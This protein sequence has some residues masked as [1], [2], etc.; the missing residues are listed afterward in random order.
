[1]Q[2]C[3]EAAQGG[4]LCAGE[5]AVGAKLNGLPRR[6]GGLGCRHSLGRRTGC[7]A[8]KGSLDALPPA[9][10]GAPCLG[11]QH[12]QWWPGG[13]SKGPVAAGGAERRLLAQV[14]PCLRAPA[15]L[16]W[17]PWARQGALGSGQ[18]FPRLEQPRLAAR[19]AACG[20]AAMPG[21]GSRLRGPGGPDPKGKERNI[22]PRPL[23]PSLPLAVDMYSRKFP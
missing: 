2:P 21:V 12:P 22:A 6:A 11:G 5:C 13:P 1:M 16:C 17:V 8:S 23:C 3:L 4:R 9:A 10:M 14:P 7:G 15:P 20:G 18:P 19:S